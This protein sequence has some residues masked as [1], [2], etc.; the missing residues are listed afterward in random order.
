[1]FYSTDL[2]TQKGGRFHLIWTLGVNSDDKSEK[3]KRK[4]ES[5]MLTNDLVQQCLELRE[6]F[7]VR[8][9]VKSFSLRVNCIL[10]TGIS[11]NL[12]FKAESLR[13]RGLA[14]LQLTKRRKENQQSTIDANIVLNLNL[15]NAAEAPNF[16]DNEVGI[17]DVQLLR[18]DL[19]RLNRGRSDQFLLHEADAPFGELPGAGEWDTPLDI[20]TQEEIEAFVNGTLMNDDPPQHA[21]GLNVQAAGGLDVTPEPLRAQDH[22]QGLDVTPDVPKGGADAPGHLDPQDQDVRQGAD[23]EDLDAQLMEEPL[24]QTEDPPQGRKRKEKSTKDQATG[25][26]TKRRKTDLDDD[27]RPEDGTIINDQQVDDQGG[28][29]AAP[30]RPRGPSQDDL[31]T[32]ATVESRVKSRV[33]CRLDL[34]ED[35]PVVVPDVVLHP[36]SDEDLED[37]QP[38]EDNL[39]L[40]PGIVG[41][42]EAG[43]LVE[44]E[45]EPLAVPDVLR[46]LVPKKK[47]KVKRR[48]LL[49]RDAVMQISSDAI[50]AQLQC[51]ED[52]MRASSVKTDRIFPAKKMRFDFKKPSRTQ[53][54]AMQAFW[55]SELRLTA[56]REVDEEDIQVM[57]QYNIPEI[58]REDDLQDAT[59]ISALGDS[60][61]RSINV[62]TS[63]PVGNNLEKMDAISEKSQ[64]TGYQAEN[65]EGNDALEVPPQLGDLTGDEEANPELPMEQLDEALPPQDEALPP[66][67]EGMPPQDEGL[68]PQDGG[69]PPQD[70]QVEDQ[71]AEVEGAGVQGLNDQVDPPVDERALPVFPPSS[72]LSSEETGTQL[73]VTNREMWTKVT[74]S[75]APGQSTTFFNVC[76]P[77]S[78]NRRTAASCFYALLNLETKG[79]LE[80]HQD[81]AFTDIDINLVEQVADYASSSVSEV[82]SSN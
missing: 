38:L 16:A 49:K 26:E 31:E 37:Q 47:K 45:P 78:T 55:E 71:P 46:P 34:P 50:K 35:E 27:V 5:L 40:G 74:Q 82:S 43:P 10:L 3:R 44:E 24:D 20:P 79:A 7:P 72:T 12:R 32:P 70:E 67:D 53:G 28:S 61:R 39:P 23:L 17:L 1:M 69:M 77:A 25:Q 51:Y 6:M 21:P 76:P 4:V 14:A 56:G 68:P 11:I 48:N 54:F 8:G 19:D 62:N 13:R 64:E 36:P 33:I 58:Q 59:A 73:M 75:C 29:L 57:M 81:T 65:P 9:K 2:L 52:T 18:T 22:P 41:D 63:N 60:S 30:V 15:V 80:S 42:A 66:Q